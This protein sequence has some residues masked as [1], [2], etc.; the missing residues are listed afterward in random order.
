[1]CRSWVFGLMCLP[2]HLQTC[3]LNEFE[4]MALSG[5][6]ETA[7]GPIFRKRMTAQLSESTQ[8][9]HCHYFGSFHLLEFVLKV[10]NLIR[11]SLGTPFLLP[12]WNMRCAPKSVFVF[13][14]WLSDFNIWGMEI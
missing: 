1:M 9:L 4:M 14:V 6:S 13:H 5:S 7:C 11:G 2:A 12:G 8:N 10:F 3:L